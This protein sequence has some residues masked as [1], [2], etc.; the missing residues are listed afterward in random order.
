VL[1]DGVVRSWSLMLASPDILVKF[2]K[3]FT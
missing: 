3:E 2:L 1:G